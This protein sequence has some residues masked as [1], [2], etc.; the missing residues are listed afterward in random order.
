M[1]FI[2]C[3]WVPMR[4]VYK[5]E[6]IS[7]EPFDL[8]PRRTGRSCTGW[9]RPTTRQSTSAFVRLAFPSPRPESS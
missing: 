3:L 4:F 2:H 9:L 8:Q 5:L 7:V 1:K 6:W